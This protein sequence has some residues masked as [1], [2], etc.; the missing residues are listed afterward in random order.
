MTRFFFTVLLVGMSLLRING[1]DGGENV[2]YA[3]KKLR[4]LEA[5]EAKAILDGDLPTL[6]KLWGE[7]YTV[8]A[9]DNKIR[10]RKGVAEAIKAGFI[11][12][13]SFERKVEQVLL[14][15]ETAIVMGGETVKH[16]GGP[17]DGKTVERRYTDVWASKDGRW[18]MLARHASV[19]S[20]K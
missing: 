20:V 18:V 3:E 10:D 1:V 15:G 16:L 12:Y 19:V 6:E 14:H 7:T 5:V 9:P 13:S 17:D 11:K 8:N 2:Q 4:E